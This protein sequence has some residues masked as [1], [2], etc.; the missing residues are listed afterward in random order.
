AAHVHGARPADALAA[1]AAEGQRR[2]DGVLDV[3]QGVQD[4]RAARLGVHLIGVPARVAAG[5]G[6]I[7]VDAERSRR[8]ARRRGVVAALADPGVLG[9]HKLDHQTRSSS[10]AEGSPARTP[11]Q[12]I[13]RVK[14]MTAAMAAKLV[15]A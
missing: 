1:G 2:V 4:H 8:A 13:P 6:V 9:E 12:S 14:Y 11:Y 3:D 15:S 10:E 7:A 5:L